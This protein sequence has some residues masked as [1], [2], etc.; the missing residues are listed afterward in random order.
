[1]L[2]QELGKMKRTWIMTSIILIAIGIVMIMCPVQYMGMLISALAYILLVLATV[3]GLNFLA[4]KKVLVDY[5]AL[6]AGLFAGLL[7]LFVLVHRAEV[8][9]MLGLLFGLVLLLEGINGVFNAFMYARRAGRTAWWVLALL[10]VV[11]ALFGA[12]L[13]VNPWWKVPADLKTVIGWMMLFSSVVSIVRVI[14]TWP[15]REV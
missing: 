3:M 10:S 11:T 13:L 2:F 8:L 6:T 5:V 14:L 4:S 7:G 1:M 12:I 9:P 15:F